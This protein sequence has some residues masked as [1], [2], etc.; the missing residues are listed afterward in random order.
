MDY[1]TF[2][3]LIIDDYSFLFNLKEVQLEDS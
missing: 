3:V 2:Y 1:L